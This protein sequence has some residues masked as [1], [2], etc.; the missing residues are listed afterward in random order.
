VLFPCDAGSPFF[1]CFG[2]LLQRN[3][4]GNYVGKALQVLQ[5]KQKVLPALWCACASGGQ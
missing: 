4:L 3:K 2:E 5:A 1:G